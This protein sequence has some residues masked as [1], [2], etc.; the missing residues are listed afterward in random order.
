MKEIKEVPSTSKDTDESGDRVVEVT[1]EVKECEIE[2]RE[3]LKRVVTGTPSSYF[4]LNSTQPR[5]T[6]DVLGTFRQESKSS[7]RVLD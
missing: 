7:T 2:E 6:A 1:T 4:S 5:E 3:R